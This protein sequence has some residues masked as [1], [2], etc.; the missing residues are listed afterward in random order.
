MHDAPLF[1]FITIQICSLSLSCDLL[2]I[3]LIY[4]FATSKYSY[5]KLIKQL[6][7]QS[8]PSLAIFAHIFFILKAMAKKA[9]SMKTLSFPKWRKRL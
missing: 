1:L 8:I 3:S 7:S 4:V 6:I 9:K 5:C 2:K